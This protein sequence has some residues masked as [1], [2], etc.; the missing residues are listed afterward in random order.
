M[1]EVEGIKEGDAREPSLLTWPGEYISLLCSPPEAQVCVP[2]PP[3]RSRGLDELHLG[4][5]VLLISTLCYTDHL[6]TQQ[7]SDQTA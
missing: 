5:W 3:V 4:K 2:L 7:G 1:W 6:K